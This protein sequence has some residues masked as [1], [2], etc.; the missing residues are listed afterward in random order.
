[1]KRFRF[2]SA[3]CAGTVFYVLV[4]FFAGRDGL[5]A[6]RQQQE[7]KRILSVRT[8]QIQKINDS[9]Q[10]EFTA[11]EK[12]SEVIAGL[13]KK[14]GYVSAG[15]KIVKINGLSFDNERIYDPGTPVKAVE[16][17]YLPEWVA[18]ALGV[19]A[20]FVVYL[21]LLSRDIKAGL[22]RRRKES[23]FIGGVPVYDL[24]QV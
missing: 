12:D 9:L 4:S 13:A 19:S 22:F 2:L 23:V 20:F 15:D 7:Q 21:Y 6:Y 17:D 16:P 1:M 18:K 10:L 8:G 3:A 24:P 14:L 5:L 11:L